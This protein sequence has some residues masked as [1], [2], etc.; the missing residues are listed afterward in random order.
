MNAE[1]V[2]KLNEIQTE[3]NKAYERHGL[4]LQAF[5]VACA[6]HDWMLAQKEQD[7]ALTNLNAYMDGL[8]AIR[9]LQQTL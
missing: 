7:E 9:R 4:A 8:Q 1:I 5:Q 3:C 6:R 2:Q